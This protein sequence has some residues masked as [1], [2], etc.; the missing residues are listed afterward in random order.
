MTIGTCLCG[1]VTVTVTP[2]EASLHACHCEMCRRWTGSALL[3]FAVASDGLTSDGPVRTR[4]SSD[5]A[6]RA[7]CDECG[8]NLWYR[9]TAQG[10]HEG[11]HHVSAGL[12]DDLEALPLTSEIF[13]DCKPSGWSY[14]QDTEKRTRA[15]VLA[16]FG[17]GA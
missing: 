4:A 2:A 7:W 3:A 10:P 16:A 5:W 8:S 14:A 1:A 17:D 11:D 6:E 9:V 15:E 13:H 12:F